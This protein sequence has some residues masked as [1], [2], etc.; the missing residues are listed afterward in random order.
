MSR[1]RHLRPYIYQ[2]V[3]WA[4]V[5][6]NDWPVIGA[7]TVLGYVIPYLLDI[8][9]FY[10]PVPLLSAATIFVVGVAFFNWARQGRPQLWLQHNLLAV[11][12]RNHRTRG[13]LPCERLALP[14]QDTWCLDRRPFDDLAAGVTGDCPECDAPLT[15]AAYGECPECGAALPIAA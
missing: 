14:L 7:A 12:T 6:I 4:G 11:V 10:L 5:S 3:M 1:I 8:T 13:A 2:P 15:S 9:L